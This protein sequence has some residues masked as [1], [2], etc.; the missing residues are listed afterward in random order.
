MGS[1]Q[2]KNPELLTH[3][4][5]KKTKTKPRETIVRRESFWD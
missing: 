2:I 5:K 4:K 1:E 3:E